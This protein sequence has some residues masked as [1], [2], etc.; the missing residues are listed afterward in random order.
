M[1]EPTHK[2][3]RLTVAM[4]ELLIILSVAAL[5]LT[6]NISA[7]EKQTSESKAKTESAAGSLNDYVGRYGGTKEIFVRDGG[8]YYQ[9]IGGRGGPMRSIGKDKFALGQDATLTFKRDTKGVVVEV[10]IDWVAF[11]HELLKREPSTGGPSTKS[12]PALRV[13]MRK[14][15]PDQ[16]SSGTALDAA[17]LAQLQT[18]MAYLLE[19]IYVS[20]EIGSRLARQLKEK[21]EA[22]AYAKAANQ[23]DLAEMLTRDLREWANDRHLGVRYNPGA[24]EDA[25]LDPAAW[26]KEKSSRFPRA[27]D[28]ERGPRPLPDQRM[29]SMLEKDNYHFRQTKILSGNVGYLEL[30]GFAPGPIAQEKAAQ[31]MSALEKSDAIIIDLRDCPGG[32]AEMV[33]FLA[34]YFFDAEPRVLMNRFIRPTNERIQN[35]TVANLP[36]K[37]MPETDLYI[38]VSGQTASAGESFAYTLQQFGRAKIVGEKTAGA[39]YNNIIIPLGKGLSFSVSYGRPEHPRTGKGWEAVGVLPDIAAP[40]GEAL[41]IAHKAALKKLADETTDEARKK[42]ITAALQELEAGP[43]S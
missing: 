18:I 3:I 19:T 17:T 4:K 32:S 33:D 38:L 22:G 9:R 21:F 39:G 15:R 40:A 26:E 36:G 27:S 16:S 6:G 43:S 12:D 25:V 35:K 10:A 30:A 24:S 13:P 41:A 28:S 1:R 7:Q 34:S 5:S 37:R 29:I 14:Q 2:F 11:P 42:Q 8:L 23:A 20:P 31:A